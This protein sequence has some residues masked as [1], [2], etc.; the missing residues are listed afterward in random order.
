MREFLFV[1]GLGL[2]LLM[3]AAPIL[4]SAFLKEP[5]TRLLLPIL[6]Y[7]MIVKGLFFVGMPYLYRDGVNWLTASKSRWKT[8]SLAGLAYGTA[9]VLCAITVWPGH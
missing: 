4:Y 9:I 5:T 1:R 2:C 6:A 7:A 3:A 8:A